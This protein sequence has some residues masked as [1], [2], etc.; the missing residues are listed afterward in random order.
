MF[1]VFV[2]KYMIFFWKFWG[3]VSIMMLNKSF[4]TDDTSPVFH[5]PKKNCGAYHF[6]S[7]TLILTLIVTYWLVVFLVPNNES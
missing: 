1:F 3:P 7:I 5:T 2:I 6:R 4:K